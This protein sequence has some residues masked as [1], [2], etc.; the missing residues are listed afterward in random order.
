MG[1][2]TEKLKAIAQ[3]VAAKNEPALRPKKKK[4]RDGSRMGHAKPKN[5]GLGSYPLGGPC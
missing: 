5:E 2:L 1:K 3:A 4:K